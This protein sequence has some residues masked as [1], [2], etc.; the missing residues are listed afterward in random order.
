MSD[1]KDISSFERRVLSEGVSSLDDQQLDFLISI[2]KQEQESRKSGLVG[3]GRKGL[4]K[5]G[6]R[7]RFEEEASKIAGQELQFTDPLAEEP[8]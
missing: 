1:R 2:A 7:S 8:Y 6:V 3:S 5:P 4:L